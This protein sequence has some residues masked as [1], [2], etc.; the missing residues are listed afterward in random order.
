LILRGSCDGFLPSK[1]HEICGNQSHTITIIK[2]KDSNEILG[3]YNPII[4]ESHNKF[5]PTKDSF[6]FS[7]KKNVENYILSRVKD[8]K[9]ATYNDSSYGPTFGFDLVLGGKNSFDQ[10]YC[11]GDNQ[12]SIKCQLKKLVMIFL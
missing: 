6:I 8:E 1:F 11:S 4:W 5:R 12:S 9:F 7:F 10:G 3:G 2:V